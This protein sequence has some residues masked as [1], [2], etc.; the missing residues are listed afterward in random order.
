MSVNSTRLIYL[1]DADASYNYMESIS[2]PSPYNAMDSHGTSCAGEIGM[3]R[4]NNYCGVGV[5]YNCK[6][7]GELLA[8]LKVY[9][10]QIYRT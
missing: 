8:L 2:D 10:S 1:Q 4:D 7:G 5:A 3:A 6:L 9:T